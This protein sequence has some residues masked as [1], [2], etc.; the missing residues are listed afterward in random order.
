MRVRRDII[1]R[2]KGN[3]QLRAKLVI[4]LGKNPATLNGLLRDNPIDSSLTLFTAVECISET[5]DVPISQ[6]LSHEF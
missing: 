6:I 1:E 3:R 2:I 5:L 4:V